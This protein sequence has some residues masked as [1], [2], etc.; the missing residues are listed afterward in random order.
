MAGLFDSR[1][2]AWLMPKP[3]T[4]TAAPHRAT[5]PA[6]SA[7]RMAGGRLT[8]DS[9]GLYLMNDATTVMPPPDPQSEWRLYNLD[10]DTLSRMSPAKLL[11]LM[12]DISPEVS[13]GL[14]N[15]LRLCNPGWKATAMYTD[16]DETNP[17]AQAALDAF[18]NVLADRHGSIDIPINIML[19]GAFLRGALLC[20][21]VLDAKGRMPLELA[22]P[23][24]LG[25]RFRR[26]KDPELGYIWRLGQYQN[27]VWVYLDT[28]PTV[29]YTP[30][31]PLP[32]V[33]YGRPLVSPALFT[34]LFLLGLL[35]DL[36]RVVAQ[37][38]Y[39]RLDLAVNFEK[40]AD[41]APLTAQPG[42]EEWQEYVEA[43]MTEIDTVYSSLEPDD[44]YV[45]ADT[46]TVNKPV[47][48]VGGDALGAIDALIKSLERMS[49]RA[50]KLMP[51]LMGINDSTTET[52]ANRQWEIQAA[53]VKSLQ[54]G[55]E[56]MLE[57][58]LGLALEAQGIQARIKFRF[59]ELRAAE[60]F[61]DAQTQAMEIANAMAMYQAGWISQDAAAMMI[62]GQPSDQPAPRAMTGGTA[63]PQPTISETGDNPT[64][65]AELLR[66]LRETR[67]R[68]GEAIAVASTPYRNGATNG[69]KHPY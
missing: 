32:G 2:F 49:A 66:E 7:R 31:D 39:P 65:I 3:P 37:Q 60:K 25:V 22:T 51:L 64:R 29:R 33:P 28:R 62:T 59:E 53:S 57:R 42:S 18:L 54:H 13:T 4:P 56:T 16:R 69:H 8:Q 24:P 10:S 1:L 11:G 61:R 55:L 58:L 21:L 45:H 50:M 5:P 15:W 17:V 20:E 40:L 9:D 52:N 35:H 67:D 27:G 44:A 48:A 30:I 19:L 46:I 6:V 68:V 14:W 41:S 23:D 43:V 36:R 26:D 47:G 38:G 12:V 34:S 63:V